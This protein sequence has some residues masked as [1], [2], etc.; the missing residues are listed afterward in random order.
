METFQPYR[1]TLKTLGEKEKIG[2][3]GLLILAFVIG[4]FV[5]FLY[6]KPQIQ[7]KRESSQTNV[8]SGTASLTLSTPA[9]EL[10]QNREFDVTIRISSPEKGVEAGD[11]ILYYDP[12]Y[13]KAKSITR[14]NYFK[15]FI[16]DVIEPSRI[17]LQAAAVLTAQN[18]IVPKGDGTVATIHFATLAPT[19]T[20][21]IYFDP[22]RT[23]V[24][25]GGEN[26]LDYSNVLKL[27]IR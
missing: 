12:R 11:F 13:V 4:F 1:Q 2:I 20:T 15:N 6:I 17:K 25:S 8:P 10:P 9:L 3:L 14:G 5:A 23:V 16:S 21:L 19:D 22:D 7:Q 18:I 27:T 26:I 24:A